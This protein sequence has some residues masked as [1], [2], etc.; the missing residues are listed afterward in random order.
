MAHFKAFDPN[1]EVSGGHLSAFVKA[2]PAGT[3]KIGMSMLTAAGLGNPEPNKW[4]K[5]Q[6]LLDVMKDLQESFNPGLLTR[7][8]YQ[9]AQLVELPPHWNDID[10]AL[11][12]IDVGYQMNHRGGQIGSYSC[13]DLGSQNGLRRIK[14]TIKTHWPCEYEL[15]LL[16]GLSDRF[17]SNGAEVN[18]REDD[19]SPCRK[20]GS[21]SCTFLVSWG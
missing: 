13:N 19:A 2:F 20:N 11:S 4:Y 6:S 15:G 7:M 21:D 9:V 10:I 18:V 12:E 14:M 3:E 5:L 16:Q 17:K 1:V 8:G